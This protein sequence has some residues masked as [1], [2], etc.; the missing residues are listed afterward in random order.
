MELNE[1]PVIVNETKLPVNSIRPEKRAA[2]KT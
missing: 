1:K 2:G